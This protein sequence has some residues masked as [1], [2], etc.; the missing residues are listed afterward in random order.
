[1]T[2]NTMAVSYPVYAALRQHPRII[3]RFK[4]T[5]V[6]SPAGRPF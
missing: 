6:G 5:Q 4:Y 3:D 1:M 2:P